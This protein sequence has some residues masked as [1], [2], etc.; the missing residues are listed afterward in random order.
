MIG[1]L[2]AVGVVALTAY[3]IGC[4]RH[5]LRMMRKLWRFTR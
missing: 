5:M 1:L 4:E 3:M 2:V